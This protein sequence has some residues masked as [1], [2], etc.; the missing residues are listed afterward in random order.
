[1]SRK[2]VVQ[3]TVLHLGELN[4]TQVE[5]W[6]RTIEAVPEDGR[7]RQMR[8]DREGQVPVAA[9]DVAEVILSSLWCAGRG[10][11]EIAGSVEDCGRTW[12]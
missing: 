11:S 9:D 6:Q 7:H 3:R 10:V 12:D 1:V 5:R 4:T 8:L 2:R